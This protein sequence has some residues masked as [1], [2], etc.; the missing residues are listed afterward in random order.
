MFEAGAPIAPAMF[1]AGAPIM[2]AM[3]AISSSRDGIF[4]TA[5]TPARSRAF[6]PIAPPRISNFL[7]VLG[8]VLGNL[9]SCHRVFRVG[10]NGHTR[11]K[12]THAL[13]GFAFQG[14]LGEPVLGDT[15]GTTRFTSTSAQVLHVSNRETRVVGNHY[16]AR[17]FKDLA[18][19]LDHFLF[20]CSIHS[21]TPILGL[22]PRLSFA[23]PE[24]RAFR[25]IQRVGNQDR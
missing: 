2:P 22:S 16:N 19:F 6:S 25:S 10:Q 4:D 5:S 9:G 3:V 11:Q 12:L 1:E 14:D 7:F 13:A 17:A 15:H 24:G 23:N 18:E 8:E 21:F 20:L